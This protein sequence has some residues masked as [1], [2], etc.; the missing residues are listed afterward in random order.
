MK[1]FLILSSLL[2]I[3][4]DAAR[5]SKASK[6]LFNTIIILLLHWFAGAT[7]SSGL[8]FT[9]TSEPQ[10]HRAGILTVGYTSNNQ[11]IIPPGRD[12]HIIN[13]LCPGRCTQKVWV[14][15][16]HS[17]KL[18]SI[19]FLYH[20]NY[21]QFFPSEGITVFGNMLH[22]HLAGTI[23]IMTLHLSLLVSVNLHDI[24]Y[25]LFIQCIFCR[26]WNCSATVQ[27]EW[28][29][30]CTGGAGTHWWKQEVWF[31][32]PASDTPAKKS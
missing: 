31:Q 25:M 16:D 27:R 30:W 10:R 13:S 20:S 1:S 9:Y 23:T 6:H 18:I 29:L 28:G 11:L 17:S 7:D 32:L 8:K 21:L 22:T 15:S 12:N 3:K 26:A 14:Q 19:K 24:M 2:V 5:A 4:N